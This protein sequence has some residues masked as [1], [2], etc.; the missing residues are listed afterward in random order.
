VK[1]A[2][3]NTDVGTTGA[4]FGEGLQPDLDWKL[5]LDD[6]DV[7]LLFADHTDGI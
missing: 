6:D 7:S 4:Q 3:G 1:R 5:D 2:D